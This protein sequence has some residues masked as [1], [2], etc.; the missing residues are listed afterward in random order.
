VDSGWKLKDLHRLLVASAAY[1]QD[2]RVH[3]NHAHELDPENRLLW[4]AHRRRLGGEG[5]RDAALSVSGALNPKVGGKSFRD[6]TVKL[7][8]Q[9]HEFTDPT[10]EFSDDTN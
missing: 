9:N 3:E 1:R 6:V 5:G 2:S 4:R 10:G 8:S 7:G